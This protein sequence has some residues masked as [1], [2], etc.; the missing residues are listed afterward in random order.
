MKPI[1]LNSPAVAFD[2]FGIQEIADVCGVEYATAHNW[3]QRNKFPATTYVRLVD[4][5]REHHCIAAQ[6]C[7]GM[8]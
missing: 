2:L 6:K 7:W 8:R 5:F 4:F 1:A 3:K